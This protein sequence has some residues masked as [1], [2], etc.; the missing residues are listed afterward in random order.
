MTD[1][2]AIQR[3]KA[4]QAGDR[5]HVL[6]PAGPVTPDL[7]APGLQRLRDWGL[8]VHVDPDLYRRR[9]PYDYLAGDDAL[10]L[11]ALQQALDDPECSA[12][13]CSRGG[14]GSMRLLTSLDTSAFADSPPLLVGF[15]DITALHL[16]MASRARV[17]SLHGPVIKSFRL[18]DDDP[19]HSL[20]HLRQALFGDGPRPEPFCNMRTI[21]SGQ[22]T[23]PVFGGTLSL[24][25]ALL[26]TPFC[27]DLHG[28]ILVLEEIGEADYRVDRLLTSL[29]L[30]V[31]ARGH[32]LGGLVFGRFIDC[33]G[34]YVAPDGIDDFLAHLAREFDCPVAGGAP[35]GH[36]MT[37]RCFPIGL[38][39]T[40]DADA[41]TLAFHHHAV[42]TG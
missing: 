17:A 12:I 23:G 9:P 33:D 40:L 26:G 35:V 1:P 15:S 31:E 14:Y 22:A 10:R 16:F 3:P 4:L 42:C 29:R 21:A 18:H 41:G 28:A 24:L 38:P 27:P 13:I 20:A 25:T 39:A 2:L 34:V 5:V 32:R 37:N 7:M 8:E 11:R 36:G 6:S 30:A 19:H